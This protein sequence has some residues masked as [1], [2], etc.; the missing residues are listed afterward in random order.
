MD[1][2]D[3]TKPQQTGG[4]KL[5]T[6]MIGVL[7]LHV[8]V[9]GGFTVYHLMGS[10]SDDADVTLDKTHKLKADG[11]AIAD[12]TAPD[13]ATSDKSADTATTT[14]S[15]DVAGTSGTATPSAASTA[16]ATGTITAASAAPAVTGTAT[17]A[18]TATGTQVAANPPV[19]PDSVENTPET[20]AAVSTSSNTPIVISGD[21]MGQ[22]S[23]FP[24][25][26]TATATSALA[27]PP[28][29][30]PAPSA[31]AVASASATPVKLAIA[32]A[33]SVA[34]APAPAPEPHVA[35]VPTASTVA[36]NTPSGPV[37]P[38]GE[39]ASALA[40]TPANP[41]QLAPTTAVDSAE[42]HV[43]TPPHVEH[44]VTSAHEAKKEYYTVKITDSFQK[45]AHAHHITVAEL[46]A[47]N[48]IKGDSLHAGTKLIIPT[49][50]TE[51]AKSEKTHE[52][53]AKTVSTASSSASQNSVATTSHH[54]YYT[55]T[56]GDTL[57]YIAH[58]FDVTVL[59]IK[60]A[61]DV[62][63]TKQLKIGEKLRIPLKES[64]TAETTAIA[65][66]PTHVAAPVPAAAP[67]QPTQAQ[68]QPTPVAQPQP[69]P[70][71]TPEPM[72]QPAPAPGSNPELANLTF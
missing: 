57:A 14:P 61:N 70:V 1:N 38:A 49:S 32:P 34:L 41:P 69:T 6:V 9:I 3:S 43:S 26:A 71:A 29:A 4:L 39:V 65:T 63:T 33:P 56:K 25:T 58:K 8:L 46:K 18:T 13:A 22:A 40:S 5:M 53:T 17:P 66:A 72:S 2:N 35:A 55:V 50:R 7:A 48:R 67:I 36:V 10:G 45:I 51:V 47:A 62:S 54:H 28:D 60:D 11:T 20:P 27:P 19:A 68:T 23:T 21:D 12:T 31:P 42:D 16:D 52:S 24:A 44:T 37:V 64:R 59:A 15:G 30:T